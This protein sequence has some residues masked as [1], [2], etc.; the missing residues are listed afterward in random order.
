MNFDYSDQHLY[1]SFYATS[2]RSFFAKPILSL[3]AA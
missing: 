3:I 2:I 1:H